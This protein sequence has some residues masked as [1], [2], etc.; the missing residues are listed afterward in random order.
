MTKPTGVSSEFVV[1]AQE[2]A[3]A[4]NRDLIAAEQESRAGE[5][6]PDRV[7]NLFRS[8]HSLKG[9]S[10]M[11][12]LDAISRLAHDLENVLDGMR[13]GKLQL[14]ADAL[15][16]LFACVERFTDLIDAAAN[17]DVRDAASV[18]DLAVRLDAIVHGTN[19]QTIEDP[20]DQV[21]VG[22]EVLSVLTE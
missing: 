4:L 22:E 19:K 9:I 3:D 10:G 15:D 6:D 17:N 21:A 8:A 16:V 13:L 1:E 14:D 2:I 7:N 18:Q 5:V 11:F 12:G 20:L